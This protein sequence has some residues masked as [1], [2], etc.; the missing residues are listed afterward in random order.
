M[1]DF[2]IQF[3]V[4]VYLLKENADFLDIICMSSLPRKIL[5]S[6]DNFHENHM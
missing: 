3:T 2:I 1:M 6:I 4:P 5:Q